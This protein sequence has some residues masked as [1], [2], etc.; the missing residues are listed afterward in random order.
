MKFAVRPT[1]LGLGAAFLLTAT[2]WFASLAVAG[3]SPSQLKIETFNVASSPGGLAFDG[4]NIWVTD[5][6]EAALKKVRASD[7]VVLGTYVV[8]DPMFV[9]ADGV[10]VW[11]TNELGEVTKFLASDGTKEATI[12]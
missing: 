4:A 2:G 3:Q 10:S 1:I 9:A 7:G 8:V 12:V 6:F 5:Y 11:V